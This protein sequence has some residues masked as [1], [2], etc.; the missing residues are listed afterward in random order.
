MVMLDE[1][2]RLQRLKELGALTDEE[3]AQ[4]KAKLFAEDAAP[5]PKTLDAVNAFRRSRHDQ[6]LAG[7]CGGL[8]RSTGLA[9]WIW[10]AIFLIGLVFGFFTAIVYIA[11]WLLVPEE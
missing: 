9:S 5:R 10:R 11:V 4:A 6:W 1:L 2:E 8:A 3:F 7:V